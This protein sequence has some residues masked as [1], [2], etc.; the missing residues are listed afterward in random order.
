MDGIMERQSGF[1][2]VMKYRDFRLLWTGQLISITGSQMRMVAVDWQVYEIATKQGLNPALALGFIG[3]LRLIP[4]ILTALFAGVAAD[5][6]ER[7][8]VIM[9]TSFVA[10]FASII[11]AIAGG[12]ET[13]NL[14][15]VYAM[16]VVTAIASA[17]E[18]PARQALIPA[19]VPAPMLSQ[20][21]S[22][23]II[24]WQLATV[25]GPSIAGILISVYGV[26]PLY[27]ID[28]ASYLAV[29]AA[30]VMMRPV[31]VDSNR[32][33]VLMKDAFEGLK[34][35]FKHRLMSSTMLL[36]FFA[37]FFGAA[38]TLMPIFANE[39]LGVGAQGYGLM[40]A[41]PSVGAV[42]AAVLLSSRRITK[43]GP[44][45]LISVAIFGVSMAVFGASSWFPLTL[46]ALALSGA[47]DTISMIIRGTLRQLLTPDDLRG[48]MT[49]VNMIFVAG[50]PQLGEF[51][52]GITASVIGAP[53]AVLIGGILCVG[54]VTGTAIK[55]PELR[56]LD[57]PEIL[58]R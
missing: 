39:I 20:A 25:L 26:V 38:T 49:A 6:F 5:R 16:V 45:L 32:P 56:K 42:L 55:V 27:W 23:G 41:A 21:M 40:R 58:S 54:L 8:K 31:I 35:V 36:D 9:V 24:S 18:M 30:A 29:V 33:P 44:V 15:I 52:V 19:L 13:P 4:M 11:L 22:A 43:Q 28:A 1:L 51:V 2:S 17:F 3:L 10:L 50:G 46:I 12:L 37:T 34:F 47:A 57:T 53:L 7:R 48:R 14:M